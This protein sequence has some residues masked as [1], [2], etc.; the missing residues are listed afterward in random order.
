[1]NS[2][3]AC[4]LKEFKETISYIEMAK[5]LE[6]KDIKQ[7]ASYLL[8]NIHCCKID[9]R[10]FSFIFRKFRP[11]L[12]QIM[13]STPNQ[14]AFLDQSIFKPFSKVIQFAEVNYE[15]FLEYFPEQDINL[16]FEALAETSEKL[17]EPLT[18]FLEC[19]LTKFRPSFP[20]FKD[21]ISN[22]LTSILNQTSHSQQPH[23]DITFYFKILHHLISTNSFGDDLPEY[24]AQFILPCI[25]FTPVA[26]FE[27]A[28]KLLDSICSV[29]PKS[30]VQTLKYFIKIF[31]TIDSFHQVKLVELTSRVVYLN[32]F[33]NVNASIEWEFGEILNLAMKSENYLV[34]DAVIEVF[35]DAAVKRFISDYVQTFLPKIFDNLYRLSRRFWRN[36]QKYKTIQTIGSILKINSDV[37]EKCLVSYNRRKLYRVPQDPSL[38]DESF[39][40]NQIKKLQHGFD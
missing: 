16:V 22:Q 28:S 15:R 9:E 13:N 2:K 10:L 21:I 32:F 26:N 31:N 23:I 30:Q 8:A 19:I 35:A 17:K 36:E 12:Y 33:F 20:L 4:R 29:S 7:T 39:C 14:R 25:F 1:M 24:H 6:G 11:F 40:I 18:C 3:R 38:D 37:F 5:I 34:V 27:P